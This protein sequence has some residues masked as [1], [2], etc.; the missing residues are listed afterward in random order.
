MAASGGKEHKRKLKSLELRHD[1]GT[2]HTVYFQ[3]WVGV[4]ILKPLQNR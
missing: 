2:G 3:A 1:R 4:W